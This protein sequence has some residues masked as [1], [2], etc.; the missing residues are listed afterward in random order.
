MTTNFWASPLLHGQSI[1][2][3]SP[4]VPLA[5]ADRNEEYFPHSEVSPEGNLVAGVTTGSF[6]HSQLCVW[7]ICDR[8]EVFNRNYENDSPVAVWAVRSRKPR[9][10]LAVMYVNPYKD[11]QP[12]KQVIEVIDFPAGN[13]IRSIELPER[14]YDRFLALSEDGKYIAIGNDGENSTV[15]VF[16]T[17]TGELSASIP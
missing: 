9:N 13:V 12:E 3:L 6:S 5:N 15:R 14:I 1:G 10:L 11:D 2:V 4:S 8:K 7:T 17:A 16:D